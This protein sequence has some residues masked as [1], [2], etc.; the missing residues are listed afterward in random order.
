MRHFD[1]IQAVNKS[2]YWTL[3]QSGVS[4]CNVIRED[5]PL[6]PLIGVM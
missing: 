6:E 5:P 1:F 3:F 2:I 4:R